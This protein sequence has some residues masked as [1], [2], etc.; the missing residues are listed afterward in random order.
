MLTDIS[1]HWA[2]SAIQKAVAAGFVNGYTD[3]TF[4][5]NQQVNR[6]EFITMLARALKLPESGTGDFKDN[7]AI[8]AWAKSY[9]AQ[10]AAAGIVSGYADGT[11]R[12]EQKLSRAELTVMI[13]RSLG[14]TVDP[15]A[16][17]T[18]AD[19]GAVPAWAAPY[20]A[21]AVEKSLVSGIGQNRFAPNQTATRAEAVAL[22]VNMLE[23]ASE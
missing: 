4:R 18:F 13:V 2:A 19:A 3:N 15:Q 12:P 14:I 20:V 8:P 16:K 11:F 7:S 1:S 21:A 9:A 17:L 22:I 23:N 6:A 5:P 10:A